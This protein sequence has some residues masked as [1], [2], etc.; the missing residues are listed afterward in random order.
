MQR[1]EITPFVS[2]SGISVC[3]ISGKLCWDAIACELELIAGNPVCI[4]DDTPKF[5]QLPMLL[6]W[7]TNCNVNGSY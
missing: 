6:F 3:E 5:L 2:D 1:K 7:R 4:I